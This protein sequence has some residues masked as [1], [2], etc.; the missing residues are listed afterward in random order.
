MVPCSPMRRNQ[1]LFLFCFCNKP[2]ST[3]TVLQPL[4]NQSAGRPDCPAQSLADA[5]GK[6]Q[7]N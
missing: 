5:S 6:L 7:V 1:F 2:E 4:S 3:T